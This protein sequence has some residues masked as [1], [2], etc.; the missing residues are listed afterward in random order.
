MDVHSGLASKQLKAEELAGTVMAE[1]E[2]LGQ[3]LDGLGIQKAPVKFG[4]EKTLRIL[5]E[6]APQLLFPHY[7]F[8]VAMLDSDNS[9]LRYGAI[10]TLG[11]LASVDSENRFEAIFDK[12]F[13]PI[14]GPALIPAANA[15]GGAAKIAVARPDLAGRITTELLKV[16]NAVYQTPECRNVAV[17]QV[18]DAFDAFFESIEDKEAVLAMVE[19]QLSNSR[20]A[21]RKRAGSFMKRHGG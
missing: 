18:I 10:H 6:K 16:E 15:I 5:S 12:Y 7:D 2:L 3:V 13:S 20:N 21:T 1:P 4:C 9:F 8:F 17:G 11:N 19:R 14:P